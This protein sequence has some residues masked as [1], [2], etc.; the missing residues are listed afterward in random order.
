MIAPSGISS[1]Q[2]QEGQAPR[3]IEAGVAGDFVETVALRGAE[4]AAPEARAGPE[5]GHLSATVTIPQREHWSMIAPGGI[6]L[7]Q[8]HEG[9]A[10]RAVGLELLVDAVAACC[11]I[12][13]LAGSPAPGI[14]P[15]APRAVSR[16]IFHRSDCELGGPGDVFAGPGGAATEA[17]WCGGG[18]GAG[19]VI[20][21][22]RYCASSSL[23]R[24]SRSEA[25]FTST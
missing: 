16:V 2:P 3:G 15:G 12:A 11:G 9:Q 18:T 14:Q 8:P 7:S 22:R 10:P 5:G 1:S 17:A 25:S 13:P 6:L 24:S 20:R 21:P 23:G 19:R 4:D